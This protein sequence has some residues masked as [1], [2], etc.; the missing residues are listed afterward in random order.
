LKENLVLAN[1][2]FLE[3]E[4]LRIED[5]LNHGDDGDFK[6]GD[7]EWEKGDAYNQKQVARQ[8]HI[9]SRETLV[10]IALAIQRIAEGNYG[11]CVVCGKE[12]NEDRLIALPYASTCVTCRK[13]KGLQVK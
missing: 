4:L 1:K 8:N 7:R 6:E 2:K 10:D 3:S 5:A 9:H 13:E 12:I 11:I